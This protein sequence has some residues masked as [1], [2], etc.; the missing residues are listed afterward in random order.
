MNEAN[1]NAELSEERHLLDQIV[2]HGRLNLGTLI[3][4]GTRTL[5]GCVF[6]K[7]QEIWRR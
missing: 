4:A 5:N 2:Q 6:A 1:V 3:T 7:A